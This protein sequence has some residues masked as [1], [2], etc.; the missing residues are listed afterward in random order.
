VS[1]HQLPD[2]RWFVQWRNAEGKRVREYFGRGGDAER[3]ARQRNHDLGLGASGLAAGPTFADLAEQYFLARR[4]SVAATTRTDLAWKL[5]GVI[6]PALGELS[7]LRVDAPALD[8]Y[9][10]A[11]L[12]IGRKR[13]SVHRELSIIRA[14]LRWGVSRRL[15]AHNPMEGYP[16]PSRD[17]AILQPPTSAEL[18]AIHAAAAPHLQ[19][20]ILL[21]AYT[22]MRPGSSELLGLRWQAVD[23]INGTIFVESAKKGGMR[24]RVVPIAEA[25]ATQLRIWL[26]ADRQAGKVEFVVHYHGRRVERIKTAWRAALVRAG[27]TRRI[28]PY[29]LRHLAAST[30]LDAGADL[31]SVSEILG[32]SS[33]DLTLRTYQHTSTALRRDAVA[34]IGSLL[35]IDSTGDNGK[36]KK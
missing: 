32:H 31:K 21:A 20:A 34:K 3:A 22:G 35:P 28:R 15:I 5:E 19:R 6:L 36:T 30:M 16:M 33:P 13:T 17:D 4:S 26:Q 25:L 14:V 23:L 24:A 1:V 8:Q 10:A 18:A 2:G 29:D 11:R 7:A 12:A 9:V 27:I